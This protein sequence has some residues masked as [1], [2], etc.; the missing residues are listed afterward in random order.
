[1]QKI[2]FATNVSNNTLEYAKLLLHSLKVNLDSD[3]HQIIVFVDSD[4]E[5]M[6]DYLLSVKSEFKDLLI[7]KNNLTVPVGYA[8]NTTIL[9]QHA[10]YEIVSYLQSDMVIGPHYDTE[11]LKHVRKGRILSS[12]RVEPPLHGESSLT[13][14][15]NFGLHPKE[16]DFAQWNTFSDSVKRDELVEHFFAPMTYYK[17]D[18]LALGGYDTVFRRS[19]ED[20]DLVQRFLHAGMEMVQTFSANVYHFT[21]VSSRGPDWFNS[22]NESAK[23][24][25]NLQLEAD[26]VELSRFIRK[27]GNFVHGTERLYK[28]DMD[29]VAYDNLHL[30]YHLEPF[31]TRVWVNTTEQ[32]DTLLATYRDQHDAANQLLGFSDADWK[33]H[34]HLYRTERFDDIIRTGTPDDYAIKVEI[35]ARTFPRGN[36]FLTNVQHLYTLFKNLEPGQY[37]LDGFNILINDV[38]ALPTDCRADNPAFDDSLLTIY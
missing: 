32:R 16:F 3:D 13:I 28:L 29:L 1:M 35:K 18:W 25:V 6:L 9:A 27:W 33:E 23:I 31:F 7:I 34:Q 36:E 4:N 8:R 37:E 12:T 20:S 19:R 5:N 21:C 15:K 14:T 38:K 30:A 17:E 11:I 10:K 26:A 22:Q 24:R 2:T